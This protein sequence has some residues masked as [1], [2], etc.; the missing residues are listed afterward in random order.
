MKIS[1]F[2]QLTGL[3]PHT[4]RYYEKIGLL[5]VTRGLNGHRDYHQK[6]LEWASFVN[7]L[8]DTGMPLKQIKQYAQ[9]RQQGE[10]TMRARQALLRQ[11]A[12]QLQA[13]IEKEQQ[14]LQ[15]VLDKVQ[16]YEE[17]LENA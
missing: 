1:E 11:H 10:P 15:A 5:S 2:S 4:L 16:L 13:S 6:D 8:R 14:H 7:R 3:S 12:E 9:L 17:W